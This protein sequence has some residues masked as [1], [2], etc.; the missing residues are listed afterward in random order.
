M[1]DTELIKI[2]VDGGFSA[3]IVFMLYDMRRE[4]REQREQIWQLLDYLVRRSD[5]NWPMG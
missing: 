3:V 2:L 5:Q 4:S 1:V